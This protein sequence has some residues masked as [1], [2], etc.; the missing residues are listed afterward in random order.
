MKIIYDRNLIDRKYKIQNQ[1]TTY[2][3][4]SIRPRKE[5]TVG[6]KNALNSLETGGLLPI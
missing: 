2:S 4:K 5:N 6:D 1:L 3:K